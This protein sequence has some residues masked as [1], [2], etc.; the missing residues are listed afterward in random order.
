[1]NILLNYL[2]SRTIWMGILTI[3][4]AAG[5]TYISGASWHTAIS[6]AIGAGTIYFRANAKNIL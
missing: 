2:R 6:A 3:S 5:N 1:M 4:L